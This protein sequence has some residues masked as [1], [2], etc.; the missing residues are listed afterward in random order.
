MDSKII[1]PYQCVPNFLIRY[2]LWRILFGFKVGP[3]S[4]FSDYLVHFC[5]FALIICIFNDNMLRIFKYK[6]KKLNGSLVIDKLSFLSPNLLV[7]CYFS[8]KFSSD[9]QKWRSTYLW[10]TFF[11]SFYTFEVLTHSVAEESFLNKHSAALLN[12]TSLI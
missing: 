12:I 8:K 10:N 9:S 6:W 11:H 1:K 4:G 2:L 3:I 5:F 7:S